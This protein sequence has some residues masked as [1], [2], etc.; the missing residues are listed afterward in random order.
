MKVRARGSLAA[1][2]VTA[3]V[4]AACNNSSSS[5][6]PVAG[7]AT[8]TSAP[9]LTTIKQGVLTVG[10]CLDYA[11]FETVKNGDPTGFDVEI[12]DAIAAK[13]GFDK[14]HVQ[15]TKA[16]F[17]TIFTAV[18]TGQFDV[19]AAAVTS[20]GATGR[21]RAQ[22]VAFSD[23]YFNSRQSF[24]VNSAQ[25][26]STTSTDQ[27]QSGDTVG[28]QKGT[29]GAQWAIDNLQPKGISIKEYTSATDAFRDLS[30]G[31]LTG[32]INDEASSYAIAATMTDVKVVESIDT[33]EKY[34]FAFAPGSTALVT[35]WNDGL[36]Q[37]IADGEYATIFAKYFP[38]TPVPPEYSASGAS[39]S[40]SA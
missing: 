28:V 12:T 15:W 23:Y 40:P 31:N 27:L 10:S 20:T 2:V 11:P 5:S 33:N 29:T 35:A 14:D 21:K 25:S 37:I 8:S 19:V 24:A 1:L 26:P 32:I 16:N 18:A 13:L 38:G 7:G 17:N 30:A 34:S 39:S 4:A 3:F 6:A 9:S 22:T 36:K